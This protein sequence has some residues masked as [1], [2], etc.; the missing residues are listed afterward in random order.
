MRTRKPLTHLYYSLT[1]CL[2]SLTS[3]CRDNGNEISCTDHVV[4]HKIS[5]TST[6][7]WWSCNVI[8]W[9]TKLTDMIWSRAHNLLGKIMSDLMS[10]YDQFVGGQ[11]TSI[12]TPWKCH[13]KCVTFRGVVDIVKIVTFGMSRIWSNLSHFRENTT[14]NRGSTEKVSG[15][16]PLQLSFRHLVW[17]GHLLSTYN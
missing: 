6:Q 10:I 8:P 7:S 2:Q 4:W 16:P 11:L 15:H 9:N 14:Q 5:S 17:G 3:G 12:C 13:S 1:T